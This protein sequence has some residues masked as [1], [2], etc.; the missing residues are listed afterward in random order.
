[1]A[2]QPLHPELVRIF[3]PIVRG[4]TAA[5]VNK[6]HKEWFPKRQRGSIVKSLQKRILNHICCEEQVYR[7][8]SIFIGVSEEQQD[9]F[10]AKGDRDW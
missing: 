2:K 8:K 9:S 4:D 10:Y 7:I 3:A 5:F 1:M 6:I